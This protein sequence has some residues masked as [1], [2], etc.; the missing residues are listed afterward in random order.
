MILL[1]VRRNR[2]KLNEQ[3]LKCVVGKEDQRISTSVFSFTLMASNANKI[4]KS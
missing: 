2:L 1:I 4:T 3:V